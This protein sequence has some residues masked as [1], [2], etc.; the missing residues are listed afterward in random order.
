M[1]QPTLRQ[2]R[3][4]LSVVA[5]GS[6]SAAARSLGLTQPAA[7][8]QLRELERHLGVRLLERAAGL[9]Q[10]TAAGEALLAPAR[11]ALAAADDA[12]AAMAA[13]RTG[14]AGRVRLGTGATAC[15]YL[16]PPI[17]ASVR[18]QMPGLN[19][20]VATGNTG[21]MVRQVEDGALDLAVVTLPV[22]RSRSLSVTRLLSDPMVAVIPRGEATRFGASVSAAELNGLPL[23]LYESGANVRSLVEGWFSAAGLAVRPAMELGNV[24]AI[25]GLVASGLGCSI[26]PGS[27]TASGMKGA[28][29]LKLR[30]GM[31]RDLALVLRKEKI[32]DR[33][34]RAV[35]DALSR[36]GKPIPPEKT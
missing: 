28:V 29:A 5:T 36:L 13:H 3:T 30:P 22:P 18:K 24:E 26:L 33:G 12:I 2:M 6:V 11:R 10:P 19:L 21:D 14:D 25:K 16:L 34:L 4:F 8:Q 27:A 7:S 1:T 15:I 32:I 23:I 20:S 17:L 35:L 31:K 9:A